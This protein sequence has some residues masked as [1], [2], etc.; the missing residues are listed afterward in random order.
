MLTDQFQSTQ[1]LIAVSGST[2]HYAYRRS[3]KA[4]RIAQ[5]KPEHIARLNQ[6]KNSDRWS[7]SATVQLLTHWYADSHFYASGDETGEVAPP[8]S[9]SESS[10]LPKTPFV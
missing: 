6:T 4:Y 9:E 5:V 7:S 10:L 1:M 8:C 2:V 3:G